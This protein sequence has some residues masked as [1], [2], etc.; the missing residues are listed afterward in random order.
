MKHYKEHLLSL[1]VNDGWELEHA[2]DDHFEWF[3][4]EQWVMKSVRHNWGLEVFITFMVDP[5]FEGPRKKGQGVE[6]FVATTES[7]NYVFGQKGL[8]SK[9]FLRKRNLKEKL[10]QFVNQLNAF[11]SRSM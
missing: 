7:P 9:C 2:C 11:R 1:M 6:Q 4:D 5:L 10:N 8:I 3:I